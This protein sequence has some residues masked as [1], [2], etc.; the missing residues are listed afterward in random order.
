[1]NASHLASN[2]LLSPGRANDVDLYRRIARELPHGAV[3]VV[4][5][6]MRYLVAQGAELEAAGF[7]PSHFEGRTVREA[8]PSS[9]ADQREADYRTVLDGGS[10]E[11]A[12]EVNQRHYRS[13]G[14]PLKDDDGRPQLAL[15]V[16]Y[17][18]TGQVLAERQKDKAIAILGH[19]L[20][21]P[22]ATL[23]MG[24]DLLK[25]AGSDS[26][27]PGAVDLMERQVKQMTR[28]VDDLLGLAFL[29]H[30]RMELR[31]E[32]CDIG[33]LVDEVLASV[34]SA[35][36]HKRQSLRHMR[37]AAPL[38][39]DADYGKLTQVLTNLLGNA[40]KYTPEG[41]A[42]TVSCRDLGESVAVSIEDT[43]IG[44]DPEAAVRLFDLFSR[45]VQHGVAAPDVE[46]G[47]GI[48]LWVARQ[49]VEAHGGQLVASSPGP[50]AGSIFT[51]TIPK[52][53]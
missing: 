26:P 37:P 51:L 13:Y 23:N 33:A 44:L 25:R 41:G 21:N 32:P 27:P 4:D 10:F 12:H 45:G 6:E 11:R 20:R 35:A 18:V 3:F 1:M 5:R 43:G 30:G 34:A 31:R 9:L 52:S 47:L 19:E 50:G 48:G 15:V 42:A 2:H 24:V 17:D 14:M 36:A 29:A 39:V 46:G 7:A 53:A 22:L 16:S 8:V 49:L 40:I 28:M 38:T